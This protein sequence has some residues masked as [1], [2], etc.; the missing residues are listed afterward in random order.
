MRLLMTQLSGSL[1]QRPD[2][3]IKNKQTNGRKIHPDKILH[4][5]DLSKIIVD[6]NTFPA[7]EN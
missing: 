6:G 4:E 5:F 3:N 1:I 2:I 7:T